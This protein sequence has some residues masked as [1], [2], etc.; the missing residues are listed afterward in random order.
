ME[1]MDSKEC[2]QLEFTKFTT[3]TVKSFAGS[4]SAV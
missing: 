2:S 4:K 1:T 3:L